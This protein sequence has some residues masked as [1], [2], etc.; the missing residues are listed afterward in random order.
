M[1]TVRTD[2]YDMGTAMTPVDLFGSLTFTGDVM[3]KRLP[4]R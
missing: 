1:T 2:Y 3:L 4:N